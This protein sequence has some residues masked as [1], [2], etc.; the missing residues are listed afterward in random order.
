MKYFGQGV[1]FLIFAD[2]NFVVC[3]LVPKELKYDSVLV[4][5]RGAMQLFKYKAVC[6]WKGAITEKV[7]KVDVDYKGSLQ[8]AYGMKGIIFSRHS[9]VFS[10]TYQNVYK[11]V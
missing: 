5:G 8:L 9:Q 6:L 7:K 11:A 4:L 1:F 3:F 10:Y 2:V